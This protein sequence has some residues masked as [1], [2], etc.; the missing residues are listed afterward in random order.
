VAPVRPRELRPLNILLV[1]LERV[2]D[3][4]LKLDIVSKDREGYADLAPGKQT[5]HHPHRW[6]KV[7]VSRHQNDSIAFLSDQNIKHSNGNCDIGLLLLVPNKLPA[8]TRAFDGL[9]LKLRWVNPHAAIL[10][11][12]AVG[13]VPRHRIRFSGRQEVGS[14]G[15]PVNLG[16]FQ[17]AHRRRYGQRAGTE[18]IGLASLAI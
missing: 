2:G 4:L 6:N 9:A 17:P 7:R 5:V 13:I 15:E 16:E 8:A 1:D 14:R 12:S 11:G 10:E 18:C 3:G